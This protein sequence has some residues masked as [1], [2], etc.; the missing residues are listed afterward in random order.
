MPDVPG[1]ERLLAPLLALHTL[2]RDA[3]V[4][5]CT[6]RAADELSAVAA[7]ETGGAGG[8]D[9]VY[10]V[11]RV[12]EEAFMQGLA[13]LAREEPLCVV[14]EG[15][16]GATLGEDGRW[17]LLVDPIDGTRGLMYQKRSAWILTGVAANRGPATRLRDIVLAV[18][19]EIPLLKQHLSD[20]LWAIRGRKPS[21]R[22]F[23]RLSGAAE[24]L[25]LRPSRAGTIAHGFATV[26]R[27]FPGVRDVLAAIDDEVVQALV[28]PVPGRAACFEDQYASTGGELHELMF[29]HD[30]F[31]ADLRSL[32]QPVRATRGMPPGLCCH[33]YDL[34]TALIAQEA[35][36]VL[37]DPAGAALDAPFDVTTDVAWV[38]YA[39]E[40]LRDQIEPVLQDAL[41]RRGLLP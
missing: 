13:D 39:N 40:R 28:P 9:T 25:T 18:Q 14:A 33:P 7:D 3:V 27:F 29:G 15:L 22:C 35:G 32:M 38:G 4:D 41:R 5:A 12:A 10:A 20:Q 6:R 1:A 34:C 21:A 36:V 23:N 24:P 31:I 26:V 16:P 17:R 11:D 30:R 19:T 37:T 2:V 8:G